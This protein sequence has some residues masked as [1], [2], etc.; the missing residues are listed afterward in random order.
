M[1]PPTIPWSKTTMLDW[2]DFK[3]VPNPAVFESAHSTIRY[4][5]AWTVG[6]ESVDN[7]VQFFIDKI[8]IITEFFPE[9]SWVREMYATKSL[10]RH[11]QGHFDLAELFRNDIT[12]KIKNAFTGKLYHTIGKNDDQCKQYAR[13][14]SGRLLYE[15][16]KKHQTHLDEQR[17]QYDKMT[18]FGEDEHEQAVYDAQFLNL[19]V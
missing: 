11:E 10:L 19:R 6:S 5:I 14:H 13:E 8:N 18:N 9:L 1:P 2:P 15:V 17:S 16:L 7:E 4:R 3:A 12:E